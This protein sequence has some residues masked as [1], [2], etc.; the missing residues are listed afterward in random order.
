MSFDS[1]QLGYSNIK[2]SRVKTGNTLICIPEEINK[3]Y[4]LFSK[5]S[6]RLEFS[7]YMETNLKLH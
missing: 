7:F 1:S 6:H 4:L 3:D 2:G 5:Q